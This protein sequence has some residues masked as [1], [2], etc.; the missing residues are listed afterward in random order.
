MAVSTDFNR[1]LDSILKG[2]EGL[3]SSDGLLRY[4]DQIRLHILEL[5]LHIRS[6]T[7]DETLPDISK[8]ETLGSLLERIG[9]RGGAF[10]LPQ[11]EQITQDAFMVAAELF[12]HAARLLE[13]VGLNDELEYEAVHEVS[14]DQLRVKAAICYA[15]GRYE[16]NSKVMATKVSLRY[17]D[18]EI[19]TLREFRQAVFRIIITVLA[20]NFPSSHEVAET[21]YEDRQRMAREFEFGDE[22]GLTEFYILLRLLKATAL[23]AGIMLHINDE[24][25]G[26]ELARAKELAKNSGQSFY[27]WLT[28]RL[29]KVFIHM[30]SNS[31]WTALLGHLGAEYTQALIAGTGVYELWEGQAEAVRMGLLDSECS[32]FLARIPTSA[33]KTI[34][35]D[36]TILKSLHDHPGCKC[37]YVAP[38]NALINQVRDHLVQLLDRVKKTAVAVPGGFDL[39]ES[40][41]LLA[42]S[43]NVLVVT[44]EKLDM[45]VRRSDPGIL[46]ASL[47]I[48]DEVHTVRDKERGMLEELVITRLK[49]LRWANPPKFLFLS[50]LVPNVQQMTTWLATAPNTIE[51]D[52]DTPA[53]LQSRAIDFMSTGRMRWKPTRL[54]KLVVKAEDSS[55]VLPGRS[56]PQAV[57]LGRLHYL[58]HIQKVQKGGRL[59]TLKSS[60]YRASEGLAQTTAC[61]LQLGTVMVFRHRVDDVEELASRHLDTFRDALSVYV[62]GLRRDEKKRLD[63]LLLLVGNEF[64]TDSLMYR[65][66][67]SGFAYHHAGLTPSIKQRVE[68]CIKDGIIRLVI[69]SP[70]LA[71]GFDSPVHTCIID[72][73][74]R[75]EE[76]SPGVGRRVPMD[77]DRLVNLSGRA[78]RALR[79]TT[80][81]VVAYDSTSGASKIVSHAEPTQVES[82]LTLLHKWFEADPAEMSIWEKQD[83]ALG[84]FFSFVLSIHTAG[85]TKSFSL[86]TVFTS[87]FHHIRHPSSTSGLTKIGRK[88]V[89]SVE[90]D[91]YGL[92][93]EGLAIVGSTGLSP[94]GA[95]NLWNKAMELLETARRS[96]F[97]FEMR[98]VGPSILVGFLLDADP[99]LVPP[100]AFEGVY[101]ERVFDLWISGVSLTEMAAVFPAQTTEVAYW[102][103]Y[104]EN[105]VTYRLSWA[106]SAFYSVFRYIA[107]QDRVWDSLPED[108]RII[109]RYSAAFAKYGVNNV[110]AVALRTEGFSNRHIANTIGEKMAGIFEALGYTGET[111]RYLMRYI[112]HWSFHNWGISET[113]AQQMRDEAS[114]VSASAELSTRW[115]VYEF[116]VVQLDLGVVRNVPDEGDEIRLEQAIDGLEVPHG[117]VVLVAGRQI[118]RVDGVTIHRISPFLDLG[119]RYV[120]FV[121]RVR[122]TQNDWSVNGVV[123]FEVG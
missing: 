67:Q 32:G 107:V 98:Q 95:R 20:R 100:K 15:L 96:M 11:D 28:T 63:E 3:T 53:Q 12:E 31:I 91:P 74:T 90:L 13:I 19:T 85:L 54:L 121:S 87:T 93:Q 112:R 9:Y 6:A 14:V 59:W 109:I 18:K 5:E 56:Q 86:E 116:E 77:M 81:Y 83:E 82:A 38:T 110:G 16:A 103:R 73:V 64:G 24:P 23:V 105:I 106:F 65:C 108:I 94:W 76:V 36:I 66:V 123:L 52:S 29:S 34:L 80:G 48:F 88:V 47:F 60:G 4:L 45:L 8:L 122:R 27:W 43:G 33:G 99:S 97:D 84:R 101:H 7:G 41:L 17:V 62:K 30:Q 10:N 49:L 89:E 37:I 1:Q 22:D 79:E 115:L 68:R 120:A 26:P 104:I 75:W 72:G 40:S 117:V 55:D 61:F 92:T 102:S 111:V 57:K 42:D 21:L 51:N 114:T 44:P 35:A 2:V 39:F 70:T 119:T 113:A 50:A 78:G 58:N 25:F 69:C 71:E 118:G 46:S